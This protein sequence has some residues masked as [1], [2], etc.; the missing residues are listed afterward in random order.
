MDCTPRSGLAYSAIVSY[1]LSPHATRSPTIWSVVAG[2]HRPL[3]VRLMLAL[4]KAWHLNPSVGNGCQR[5]WLDGWGSSSSRNGRNVKTASDFVA[6]A[7][8]KFHPN[9]PLRPSAPPPQAML[10]TRRLPTEEDHPRPPCLKSTVI[11]GL[12]WLKAATARSLHGGV[13][14]RSSFLER[15]HCKSDR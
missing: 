6:V 2:L 10:V 5:L 3:S 8:I 15:A 1:E 14:R 7:S 9:Q 13:P 4:A 11:I 12:P